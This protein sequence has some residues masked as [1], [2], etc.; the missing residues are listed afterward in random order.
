MSS[1]FNLLPLR[2]LLPSIPPMQT[3]EGLKA[4][5]PGT[6]NGLHLCSEHWYWHLMYFLVLSQAISPCLIWC[7][8]LVYQVSIVGVDA[9]NMQEVW[10]YRASLSS[11]KAHTAVYDIDAQDQYSCKQATRTDDIHCLTTSSKTLRWFTMNFSMHLLSFN[12]VVA[13]HLICLDSHH[14]DEGLDCCTT[15]LYKYLFSC[16]LLLL[17]PNLLMW[18][19]MHISPVHMSRLACL[20]VSLLMKTASTTLC[21]P[22]PPLTMFENLQN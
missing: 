9:L 11:L 7:I 15:Y 16:V 18:V 2:F 6:Q 10:T 13:F 5:E 22:L 8:L 20:Q 12:A 4:A 17:L 1:V 19:T 14:H 3:P 21:P